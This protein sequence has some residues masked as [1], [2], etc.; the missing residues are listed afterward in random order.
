MLTFTP[1][2]RKAILNRRAKPF[3]QFGQSGDVSTFGGK[4]GCTHTVLQWLIWVWTG[5]WVTH[6]TISKVAGYPWPA[7]NSAK[8]GLR[9]SEVQ[10]VVNHYDIP[11]QVRT[12]LSAAEVRAIA[13]E[14]GPVGFGHAYSWWPE[15][16]GYRYDGRTADGKPN[17]Y[18]RTLGKA[19]KTQLTGFTGAHFGVILGVATDPNAPDI[20][21]AWEP[22]HGSPA[23][24]ER[25]AYDKM[26]VD[27]FD[28]VYNSYHRT[29]GRE[30]YALVPTER[31]PL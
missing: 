29:L 4:T 31:M 17:G 3:Q 26:Y 20:V 5:K 1:R 21:Y 25:P 24:P 9:P 6:D 30:P 10:R 13:R 28:A 19:G 16:K 15:W 11:Y 12:D 23:R 27:Q 2:L 7:H 18:A 8:R 22:N 14:R